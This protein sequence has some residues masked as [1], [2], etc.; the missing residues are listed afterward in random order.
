MFTDFSTWWS[1]LE[2]IE[3]VYWIIALPATILFLIQLVLTFI[4][5]DSEHDT[6][7]DVDA[8][9]DADH[10][11]GFFFITVKNMIAFFAIFSW[12]GLACSD[13]GLNTTLTV[14]ISLFSGIVMMAIMASLYYFMGKLSH[15]GTLN[16]KNAIGK[17]GDVYLS[18]P[19]RK[20]GLGKVQ[21]KVQ[22]ALRTLDAMTQDTEIIKTGSLVEVVDII[23]DHILLVKRSR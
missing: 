22:G 14:F 15:S 9:I 10:G 5:G 7:L 16:M 23:S 19:P 4:G 1:A 6:D 21:I 3:K 12:T 8:E 18:I 2:I 20:E 11:A 17:V 13:S